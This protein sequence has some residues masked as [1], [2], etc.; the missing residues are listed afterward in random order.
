MAS[1]YDATVT[2]FYVAYYG[3]P[4]DPEGLAF[5]SQALEQSNGDFSA[6]VSAFSTSTEATTRFGDKSAS[7]RIAD[8][9]QQLFDRAPD[10]DGL[11]F[12]LNAIE[13]GDA[14]LGDIAIQVVQ[15]AQTTDLAL[16]TLR[17]E[18]SAQ[19]TAA[20]QASGVAYD[21]YA[22]VEAARVLVAAIKPGTDAAAVQSLVTATT[23]LVQTAH[24]HPDVI[25]ALA[26]GGQLSAVLATSGG[27]ADALGAINAL[28]SIAKAAVSDPAAL[29][30]LQQNGGMTGLLNSL[31]AGTSLEDLKNNVDK[32]GL[33]SAVEI[34]TP[35]V[36]TPPV[37]TP[38][39]AAGPKVQLV[40]DTGF[41]T[42]DHVTANGQ[43]QVSGIK[44]GWTWQYSTN[45][46]ATWTAGPAA[47]DGTALLDTSGFGEHKLQVRGIDARGSATAV[48]KFTYD[49]EPIIAF[50]TGNGVHLDSDTLVTNS[51]FYFID[52][53][54]GAKNVLSVFQVSDTGAA[55]SWANI[56]EDVQLADGLHY[57][58]YL[59]TDVNGKSSPSNA[60]K[61]VM[62][63]TLASPTVQLVADTGNTAVDKLTNDGHVKIGGLQPGVTWIY[64]TD[65]GRTFIPGPV[66][67]D[68]GEAILDS[69]GD[70]AKSLVVRTV[71]TA[72]GKTAFTSTQFDYKLD[73]SAPAQGL[74]L[75]SVEGAA[76]G[77]NHTDLAHADVVFGYTGTMESSDGIFYQIGKAK[78]VL[79]DA[80][81]L[82][83]TNKTLT[84]KDVDLSKGDV[85]IHIDAKDAA[86]NLTQLVQ[87]IE[88]Q[89]ASFTATT[90]DAGI[91][92]QADK[93]S[94]VYLVDG[95][96]A[97]LV[98]TDA[99]GGGVAKGVET[100]IGVQEH[101]LQ[102]I[103]G[104]GV[105][106]SATLHNDQAG[107]AYGLGSG[108]GDL[109][110]G[111]YVWGYDGDDVIF[112]VGTADNAF[113]HIGSSIVGGKGSDTVHALVG[114][115]RF[116]FGSPEESTI[117][118]S[119][120]GQAH[121]FDTV[122]F[123]TGTPNVAHTQLFDFAVKLDGTYMPISAT[124]LLTGDETGNALLALINGALHKDDRS[125][126]PANGKVSGTFIDFS[127]VAGEH[128]NFLVI[129]ANGDGMITDNDYVVK[130]IGSIDAEHSVYF[131]KTGTISFMS[132]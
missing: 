77:S 90:T 131:D 111:N 93:D 12:W 92:L 52:I 36:V 100:T 68:K 22:A 86:G 40:E 43:V 31:P 26:A 65:G 110:G 24:D 69:V 64:S 108:E 122:I 105:G 45:N 106:A 116:V 117:V 91:V 23:S 4:A 30:T 112:A 54:G 15:G 3:R 104:V 124:T 66:A 20:V 98:H 14:T 49:I 19:F 87:K 75:V 71:A 120:E 76:E 129:D 10:Q 56:A 82:D 119:N 128:A 61:L 11:D 57:V 114:G 55:G 60:L 34:V 9:Y 101:A 37:V 51:Y 50:T 102:G 121:G 67:D 38:P 109:L 97:S 62:D 81:V 53:T 2:A 89:Y 94:H 132:A 1:S 8:I 27:K 42:T 32:G 115:S 72:D 125:L 78:W 83:T 84:L 5:W 80:T 33:G 59:V 44:S 118:A 130:I 47:V 39:L 126:F 85:E 21:G 13:N 63:G 17:Q 103:L 58:R 96:Q 18:A 25:A 95:D 16:S 79:A 35:P 127:T 70:G 48:T 6:I 113:G 88:G 29:A 41:D 107:I 46:G 73:T 99:V 7:E 28:T 74:K 123:N